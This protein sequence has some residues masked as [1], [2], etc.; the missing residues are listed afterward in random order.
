[1]DSII[2]YQIKEEQFINADITFKDISQIK[3]IFKKKLQNIYHTR[4]EY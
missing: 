3:K 1:V 4:I 2:D